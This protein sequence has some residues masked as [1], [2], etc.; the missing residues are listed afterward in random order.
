M[1]RGGNRSGAGRPLKFN[2]SGT[3][4]NI[5]LPAH[6]IKFLEGENNVSAK[7]QSLIQSDMEAQARD[8]I[9]KMEFTTEQ[10]DFIWSDWS[11]HD[12]HIAWL[13]TAT[14]G[15]I[16]SWGTASEW[17]VIEKDE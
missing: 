12:E 16:E 15:E 17:G 5:Y 13:L 6:Q 9:Y 10:L 1:A 11:N 4:V 8:R 3:R 2:Q 14:K 7:I